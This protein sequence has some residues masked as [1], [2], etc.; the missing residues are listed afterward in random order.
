MDSMDCGTES[1]NRGI[2]GNVLGIP[3]VE[4]STFP[5][6]DTS[7]PSPPP[8]PSR[9][10]QQGDNQWLNN[11]VNDFSLSSLLGHFESPIKG[12]SSRGAMSQSGSSSDIPMP[13]LVTVYNENSVDFTAK[14]AELKAKA[15][16]IHK[17]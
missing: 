11:E 5:A 2:S 3:G 12:S 16:Q 1:V 7:T 9:L 10:L 4:M 14:F 13:S 15:S 17:N 8:S 6:L